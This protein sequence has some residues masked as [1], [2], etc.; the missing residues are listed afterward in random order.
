[1]TVHKK[2][3]KVL[4]VLKSDGKTAEEVHI[5]GDSLIVKG[6]SFLSVSIGNRE[7]VDDNDRDP[8]DSM[9]EDPEAFEESIINELE[10]ENS[11][12]AEGGDEW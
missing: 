1:M 4:E 8:L 9:I 12:Q 10:E 6:I 7:E 2:L 5:D 11:S 3:E